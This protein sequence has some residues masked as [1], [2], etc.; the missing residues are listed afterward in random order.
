MRIYIDPVR[1][2]FD[3]T[4]SV[5]T[6]ANNVIIDLIMTSSKF[7]LIDR[8]EANRT[9]YSVAS[10]FERAMKMPVKYEYA[11]SRYYLYVPYGENNEN[12][13]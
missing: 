12:D 4:F 3:N 9:A 2:A 7:G 10:A 8:A 13:L 11:D 1:R 5:Y 6:E